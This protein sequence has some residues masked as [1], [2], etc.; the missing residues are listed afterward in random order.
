M[1]EQIID[2]YM[3]VLTNGRRINNSVIWHW[4]LDG[5]GIGLVK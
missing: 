4:W 5:Y 1:R 3:E 2:I